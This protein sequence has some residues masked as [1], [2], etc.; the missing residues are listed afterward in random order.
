MLR[1]TPCS[2]RIRCCGSPRSSKKSSRGTWGSASPCS[3]T[4][5]PSMWFLWNGCTNRASWI[6]TGSSSPG[7]RKPGPSGLRS[8]AGSEGVGISRVSPRPILPTRSSKSS[9]SRSKE[10]ESKPASTLSLAIL[11]PW[12]GSSVNDGPFRN[13][14][15]SSRTRSR[16]PR[17]FSPR[18]RAARLLRSR[19]AWTE[20][21]CCSWVSRPRAWPDRASGPT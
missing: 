21:C 18:P 12:P 1:P 9:A 2:S 10:R 15:R 4:A 6:P 11:T 19:R 17:R 13:A 8:L 14:S 16:R 3:A 5:F 20:A 7:P